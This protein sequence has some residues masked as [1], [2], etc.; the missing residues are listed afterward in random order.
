MT[1]TETPPATG[2]DAATAV[3]GPNVQRFRLPGFPLQVGP[4]AH[5]AAEGTERIH[6]RPCFAGDAP[7]RLRIGDARERVNDRVDV[8]TDMQTEML[9]IV[10]DIDDDNQI[11]WGQDTGKSL[12]ELRAAD[13]AGESA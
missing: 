6:E 5:L 1:T 7:A 11:P 8:R 10:A 3:S 9:E 13:A 4:A 12:R 2:A